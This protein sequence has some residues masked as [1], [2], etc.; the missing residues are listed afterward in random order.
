IDL[1][2]M[3]PHCT[4]S[5]LADMLHVSKSAVTIKINELVKL[6]LIEKTQSDSDK[7]VFYLKVNEKLVEEYRAYD[8]SLRRAL[9][10]VQEKH[11]E[12]D[13]DIFCQVLTT[14]SDSYFTPK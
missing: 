11:T 6:G 7:R 4:A 12:K 13:I 9:A 14:F 1:V 3:T 8:E 2:D 10:A 5:K